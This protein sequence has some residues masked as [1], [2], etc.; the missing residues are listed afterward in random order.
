MSDQPQKVAVI[1]GGVAGIVS[2]YLLDREFEV[3]LFEKND[4]LGGHTNTIVIPDGPDEGL[5]VDTGFIVM[6]DKTY[7][8]MH[9]FLKELE[10]PVRYSDMSFSYY[11]KKSN[12]QYAG[13]NLNGLF[14][15]RSNIF[16]PRFYS[17]LLGIARFCSEA[18]QEM[19]NDRVGS[20]SL[21]V[22]LDSWGYSDDVI[23]NYI[24]PMGAAIWSMPRD[25]IL[26]FPVQAFLRF[27]DNHGLLSF[28][29]RPKWQT[30]IGGSHS[31]VKRFQERF[32][33]ELVLSAGVNGVSR[34]SA[35]AENHGG[36]PSVQVFFDDGSSREFDKVVI[37]THADQALKLLRDPS[38]DEQRL[39]G[40]WSYQDN[41]TLLHR[42]DKVLPP[43][44][45]AWASW[46]YVRDQ[47]SSE[48]DPVS[49]SYYM[50]LLQGLDAACSYVV[51]LNHDGAIKDE[52]I[53]K[54]INYSHPVYTEASY[55]TQPELPAL[56]AKRGTYYCGSYFG[57]GFHEDAVRS[58]VSVGRE[59]GIEL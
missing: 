5:A 55:N 20:T 9:K 26:D 13:T 27:F 37:A 24:I 44:R 29:N 11:C 39:L 22:Y 50:N 25:E 30:V 38:E 33:G 7:P 17:F 28:F 40:A 59:F 16:K 31:Y 32:S 48:N 12:F 3:T 57:Y 49:V 45:R 14:A 15:Q 52:H 23:N 34:M 58:A 35:G 41:L 4:Y 18:R 36:A 51:T 21:G 46:N 42:D 19:A 6:N 47:N 54:E 10:V 2:S 8:L 43:L 1:G 56:N 53:I